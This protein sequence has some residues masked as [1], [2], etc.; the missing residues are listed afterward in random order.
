MTAA[1][2][3]IGASAPA[4]ARPFVD[5][6]PEGR[7]A[8]DAALDRYG[9]GALRVAADAGVRIVL[10]RNNETFCEH[11]PALRALT[12]SVDA[13]PV[14]PAGLF[15]LDE[16]TVYLR[17]T[18][19]MTVTH[20]FGHALDRAMGNATYLSNEDVRLRSAYRNAQGFVTPYAAAGRDEWFAECM[21]AWV[22][23]NDVRSPWPLVSRARLRLVD[24]R[25]YE[26][27]GSLFANEL[28]A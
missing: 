12:S 17:T 11:S 20:E 28:A 8:I 13:W 9:P 21:R 2:Y 15:V 7:I 18:S 25:M 10:L 6:D 22:G 16:R 24:P 26:I 5:A 27:M 1:A 19:P 14:P 23:A 3:E 4:P